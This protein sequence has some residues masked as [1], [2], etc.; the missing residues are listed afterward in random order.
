MPPTTPR[1]APAEI[2]FSSAACAPTPN[3]SMKAMARL[4]ASLS[5]VRFAIRYS[6]TFTSCQNPKR[7]ATCR[8]AGCGAS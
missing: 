7:S 3:D 4:V 5:A 1:T 2:T 6:P 8:L